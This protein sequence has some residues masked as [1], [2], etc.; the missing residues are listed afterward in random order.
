MTRVVFITQEVDPAHPLLAAT[1]SMIRALAARCDEVVVVANRIEETALPENAR[2][3]LFGGRSRLARAA[4]FE[5]AVAR[6]LSAAPKPAAVVAHMCPIYA[7]LA[8][9]AARAR[10]VPVLLWYA[11]WHTDRLLELAERMSTRVVTVHQT[12]FPI[13]SR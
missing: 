10:R 12:S 11:H 1:V 5:T 8:A 6:E 9:P 13:G 4:R 2:Y 3:R 7:V